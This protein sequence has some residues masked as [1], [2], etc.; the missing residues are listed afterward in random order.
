MLNKVLIKFTLR[1]TMFAK[2]HMDEGP[3]QSV[4]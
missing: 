1:I 4:A 2:Q 3:A